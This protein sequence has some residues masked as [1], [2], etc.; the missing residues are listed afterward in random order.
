MHD[1]LWLVNIIDINNDIAYNKEVTAL[2]CETYIREC[3]ATG[4]IPRHDGFEEE[5]L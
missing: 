3:F 4:K 2:D 5:K 1:G